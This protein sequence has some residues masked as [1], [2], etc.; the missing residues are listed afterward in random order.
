MRT[1]ALSLQITVLSVLLFTAAASAA[2]IPGMPK[3]G[4]AAT[5]QQSATD[6]SPEGTVA[7][8][9]DEEARKALLQR[10][11]AEDSARKV[12]QAKQD[13][14]GLAGLVHSMKKMAAKVRDRLNYLH[15]GARASLDE[16]PTALRG[17]TDNS[18]RSWKAIMVGIAVLTALGWCLKHLFRRATCETVRKLEDT[19]ADLSLTGRISRLFFR[20][21]V[22]VG[23]ILTLSVGVLVIYLLFFHESGNDRPVILT[24]L[25]AMLLIECT[26]LVSRFVLAPRADGLRFLPLQGETALY[27]HRWVMRVAVVGAFGVLGS[28]LLALQGMSEALHLTMVTMVGLTV[29]LMV[30]W[31]AL[32][33]RARVAAHIA[34]GAPA[35]GLRTQ[36]AAVWHLA[37]LAYALLFWVVW[38]CYIVVFGTRAM[39]PGLATLLAVPL[40]LVL[41][42]WSQ[43]FIGFAFG[44]GPQPQAAEDTGQSVSAKFNPA[45]YR[46]GLRMSFRA[47]LVAV[48]FFWLMD[49]WGIELDMGKA[50]A[51][52]GLN[53]LVTVLL[54]HMAWVLASSAIERKIN[55]TGSDGEGHGGDDGGG[56]GGDR[57]GTLLQLLRKFIFGTLLV[58]VVMIMLSSLGV[59]IGPLLAGASIVGVAIG[60]G[61]QEL[62]RDIVSG[63]F[64]LIDD[65]FRIG[66]YI[67]CGSAMGEVEHISIRSL[68]LRHHLG[69]IYTIPFGRLSQVVNY[70]RDWAIMKLK[71]H[72]P[73]DTDPGAVKKIIKEINKEIREVPELD[74]AM[75]ADIK[76]QG[77]KTIDETG[78]LMRV[79]FKTVP[80]AQFTLR[81]LV[82]AKMR[83]KFAERGIKFAT[84]R[85]AVH[86]PG[87]EDLAPEQQAAMG[88][89]VAQ[90]VE[91]EEKK[92]EKKD[93]S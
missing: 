77:V 71:Y 88:G 92:N 81:K 63:I 37:F 6:D 43:K 60:F 62:V 90:A 40:F 24:W 86:I 87:M 35:G 64:F 69:K 46:Q 72:V 74:A 3:A 23:A 93:K 1:V 5:T 12:Q 30:C 7:A 55:E 50:V 18:T 39:A 32:S 73:H 53:I 48:I 14:G 70:S 54:A 47:V 58:I 91:E 80:G 52:A 59:D 16:I 76:S 13:R 56:A 79:K 17:L 22:D 44:L 2:T 28:G 9:T 8:M 57:L 66:D 36:F 19:P 31:V 21:L 61:S 27:L 25:A 11:Q 89:A 20:S 83:R 34:A 67:E 84:K 42:H 78:L 49:A 4:K 45:R 26:R 68:R 65:A 33:N 29:M 41:D 85:V 38:A 82:L 15:S 75:L 10:M 51:R